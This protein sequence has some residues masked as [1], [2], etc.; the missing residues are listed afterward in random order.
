MIFQRTKAHEEDELGEIHSLQV[1][2]HV[3]R[4]EYVPKLLPIFGGRSLASTRLC[5]LLHQVWPHIQPKLERFHIYTQN[6]VQTYMYL[7]ILHMD[8]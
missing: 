2:V 8:E 7:A 1:H 5:G 4:T 3:Y 6:V